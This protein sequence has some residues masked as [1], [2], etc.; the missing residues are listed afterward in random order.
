MQAPRTAWIAALL[1]VLSL[2]QAVAQ[3]AAGSEELS[4]NQIRVERERLAR[5]GTL[6]EE[7]KRQALAAYDAALQALAGA[8]DFERK[9]RQYAK[10]EA[11]VR[12]ALRIL[13][14]E[15]DR[16]Q[17]APALDLPERASA[18][19]IEERLAQERSE[20]NARRQAL[21]DLAKIAERRSGRRLEIARRI[22]VLNQKLEELDD[23]LRLLNQRDVAPELR[24]ALELEIRTTRALYRAEQKALQQELKLIEAETELFPLQRDRA[25]R[26]VAESE[27]IVRQLE[28]RL[29]AS[30]HAELQASLEKVRK[31]RQAATEAHALLEEP[32]AEVE[33]LAEQLWAETGVLISLEQTERKLTELRKQIAEVDSLAA[34]TRR[35]FEAVRL[36]GVAAQWIPNI[37]EDLPQPA[38]LRRALREFEQQIPAVQHQLIVLEEQ[39]AKA[40]DINREAKRYLSLIEEIDGQ[41]PSPAVRS[42]VRRLVAQRREL[43]DE[44]IRAYNRYIDRLL[45]VQR[46]TRDLLQKVEALDR[47]IWQRVLWS[48][49]V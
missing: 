36:R 23:R 15:L 10:R 46:A 43:L 12:R 14:R 5:L 8:A 7:V 31:L 17:R 48:R 44:A 25:E 9:A 45:D 11:D 27:E 21:R 16:P 34:L 42:L 32:A 37:P 47:Y 22:G 49:S 29:A 24:R 40:G 13:Q 3:S 4:E 30:R 18:S 1:C 26:R 20:L 33:K 35:K 6:P 19:A 41:A 39:R 2:G 28:Q 38:A